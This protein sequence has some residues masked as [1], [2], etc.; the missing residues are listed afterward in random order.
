MAASVHDLSRLPPADRPEIAVAGR[1][2]VGKSALLNR[3]LGRRKL[4]RVSQRPGHTRGL[5]FYGVND[6]FYLV[7][8]P[9]YGFARVPAAVRRQWQALVE[10]YLSGRA[11]LRGVVCIVDARRLPDQADVDLVRYVRGLGR[12]AWVVVNKIDKIPQPRRA[13]QMK[14]IR[15]ALGDLAAAPLPCSARTGEGVEALLGLLWNA[16]A[17]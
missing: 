3:L 11:T 7:D 15:A 4:A 6:A 9:G 2:N 1:S 17:P 12:Q 16:A 13:A 14:R 10:G 8:L 5:N